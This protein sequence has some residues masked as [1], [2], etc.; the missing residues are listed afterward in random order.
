MTKKMKSKKL[1]LLDKKLQEL[2]AR[3]EKHKPRFYTPIYENSKK[4]WERVRKDNK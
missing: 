2:Q 4:V 3:D 1:D